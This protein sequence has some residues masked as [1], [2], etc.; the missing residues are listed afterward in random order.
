MR[1]ETLTVNIHKSDFSCRCKANPAPLTNQI[2]FDSRRRH[3]NTCNVSFP[4]KHGASWWCSCFIF[5]VRH[6]IV[7]LGPVSASGSHF[8]LSLVFFFSSDTERATDAHLFRRTFASRLVCVWRFT[9]ALFRVWKDL[10]G[11][12]SSRR[13]TCRLMIYL[14]DHQYPNTSARCKTPLGLPESRNQTHFKCTR[15]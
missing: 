6:S 8:H 7:S 15:K 11:S 3:I 1:P 2:R 9:V 5:S 14:R 4:S 12:L 13:H 10:H